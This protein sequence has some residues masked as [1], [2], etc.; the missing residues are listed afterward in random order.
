MAERLSRDEQPRRRVEPDLSPARRSQTAGHQIV[1][2]GRASRLAQADV[3]EHVAAEC[4]EPP[5]SVVTAARQT[6][7]GTSQFML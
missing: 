1:A 5:K 3:L 6:A 2:E 7:R 4:H